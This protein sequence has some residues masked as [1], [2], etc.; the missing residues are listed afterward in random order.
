[1]Y[2]Q[3]TENA[4]FYCFMKTLVILKEY[5]LGGCRPDTLSGF[6]MRVRHAWVSAPLFSL[7]CMRAYYT[8]GMAR[9]CIVE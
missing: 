9:V 4:T 5:A 2:H 1:M 3:N 6:A 7:S 8:K